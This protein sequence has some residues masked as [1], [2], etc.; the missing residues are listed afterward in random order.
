[1]RYAVLCTWTSVFDSIC[2][3]SF[4]AGTV[5]IFSFAVWDKS[6]IYKL[7]KSMGKCSRRNGK[8]TWIFKWLCNIEKCISKLYGTA[9]IAVFNDDIFADG[10]MLWNGRISAERSAER[11]TWN[12]GIVGMERCVD[13]F[14]DEY[15]RF[16]TLVYEICT[17]GLV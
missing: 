16:Y 14:K 1:M 2:N 15:N 10:D 13:I 9:G 6:Y 17:T 8:K 5:C 7:G 12:S 11:K 4:C 3:N